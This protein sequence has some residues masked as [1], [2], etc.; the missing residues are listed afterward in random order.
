MGC[1]SIHTSHNPYAPEFKDLCDQMGFLVMDEI[2][3]EWKVA[4][5]Q[6]PYHGY[7]LSFVEWAER[8]TTDF[9]HRDRNHPSVVL[10]IAGNEVGDRL[11]VFL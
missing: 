10:W 9:I 1:N 11:A 7:R 2:F 4:K 8:D 6:T 5:G 3:D